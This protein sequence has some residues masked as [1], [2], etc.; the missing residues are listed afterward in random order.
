MTGSDSAENLARSQ[1]GIDLEAPG[2]WN[3]SIDLIES[4]LARFEEATGALFD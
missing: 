1:L 4:D 3:A 2:F